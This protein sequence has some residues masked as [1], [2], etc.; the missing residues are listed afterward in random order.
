[1]LFIAAE[2]FQKDTCGLLAHTFTI[3]PPNSVRHDEPENKTMGREGWTPEKGVADSN[4]ESN[5][6]ATQSDTAP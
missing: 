3:N 4:T 6:T 1:M 5:S 2:L